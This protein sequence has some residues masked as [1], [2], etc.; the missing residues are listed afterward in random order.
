MAEVETNYEDNISENFSTFDDKKDDSVVPGKVQQDRVDDILMQRDSVDDILIQQDG[1]DDI[2]MP[3]PTTPLVDVEPTED[4]EESS[5][6][7][8]TLTLNGVEEVNVPGNDQDTDDEGIVNGFPAQE[9]PE[10]NGLTTTA[11]SLPTLSN[12]TPEGLEELHTGNDGK[13]HN[14]KKDGT[15]RSPLAKWIMK[16]N[17]HPEVVR[18]IYWVE[19]QRTTGVFGGVL[20]LLLSLKFYSLIGV[21][22]TFALSLLV[23]AFLYRIGMTIVKAVQK[24]SADHPFKHLLEEKI[25]ISEEAMQYWSSMARQCIN[26]GIRQTQS[27]FLVRDTVASLKAMI[28]FWLISYIASCIDFVSICI[29]GTVILFTVPKVYEEKQREIDQLYSLVKERSCLACQMIEDKLPEKV[30]VYLKKTKCE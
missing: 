21:A 9:K 7:P 15:L 11:P 22:M 17:L 1:V 25:E 13:P 24:T 8:P 16:Q 14:D 12:G 18:L 6:V 23:V 28:M 3:T 2:L 19:L 26:Q 20:L 4:A 30:K 5:E 27:L 29:V 10:L